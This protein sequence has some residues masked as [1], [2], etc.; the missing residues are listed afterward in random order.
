MLQRVLIAKHLL[1]IPSILPFRVLPGVLFLSLSGRTGFAIE[2]QAV[3][4]GAIAV[5][6]LRAGDA[7]GAGFHP[8]LYT[9][10]RTF[11]NLDATFFGVR[12]ILCPLASNS[13]HLS[14]RRQ[15]PSR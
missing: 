5:K 3:P 1:C 11:P 15:M 13:L 14:E 6:V 10:T 4:P 12:L 8:I 9:T 2:T 7:A